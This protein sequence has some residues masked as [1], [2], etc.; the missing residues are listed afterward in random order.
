MT[1]KSQDLVVIFL[2]GTRRFK[3]KFTIVKKNGD[4]LCFFW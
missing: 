4:K 3:K 1:I 2:S